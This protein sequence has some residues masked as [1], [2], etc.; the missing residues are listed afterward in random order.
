[1]SESGLPKGKLS[2]PCEWWAGAR[3]TDPVRNAPASIRV[4]PFQPWASDN[5][6]AAV[7]SF[8]QRVGKENEHGESPHRARGLA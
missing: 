7:R 2:L 5:A 4:L 8:A 3:I 1:M 6:R